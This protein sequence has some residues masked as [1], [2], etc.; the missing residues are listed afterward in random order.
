MNRTCALSSQLKQ[1]VYAAHAD[2]YAQHVWKEFHH[3]KVGTV[4][5]EGVGPSDLAMPRFGA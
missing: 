1:V 4:T 2:D 3:A 5:N